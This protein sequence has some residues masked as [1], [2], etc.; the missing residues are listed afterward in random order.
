MQVYWLIV[1]VTVGENHFYDFT[2]TV[3]QSK[4]MLS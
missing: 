2:G 3:W 4:S 1:M